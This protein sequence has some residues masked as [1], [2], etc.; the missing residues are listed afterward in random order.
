LLLALAAVLRFAVMKGGKSV[1][2][3]GKMAIGVF[4]MGQ[5]IG[6]VIGLS[7]IL[8]F[9]YGVV[10]LPSAEFDKYLMLFMQWLVALFMGAILFG[11]LAANFI[12]GLM[13]WR[14]KKNENIYTGNKWNNK[15]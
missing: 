8:A 3:S 9:G 15:F 7:L 12:D 4:D 5:M 1:S 2:D 6:S 13:E 10:Y 14:K 11:L